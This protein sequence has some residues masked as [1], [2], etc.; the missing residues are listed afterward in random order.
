MPVYGLIENDAISYPSA[1]AEFGPKT[2]TR[3]FFF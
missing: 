2:A 3:Q 1:A